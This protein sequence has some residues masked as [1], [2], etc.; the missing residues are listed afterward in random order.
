[1]A[2]AAWPSASRGCSRSDRP[3]RAAAA[4]GRRGRD[5]TCSAQGDRRRKERDGTMST[6]PTARDS[7]TSQSCSPAR[8][9]RRRPATWPAPSPPRA[10]NRRSTGG[11]WPNTGPGCAISMTTS[12]TPSP[13][14]TPSAP[15]GPGGTGR[16]RGRADPVDRPRRPA[17]ASRRRH[18]K[19][20]KTVTARVHRAL[21]LLDTHHPALAAHLRQAV[22]TGTTCRYEP[23][24]SI[25]SCDAGRPGDRQVL[26]F[27]V[28]SCRGPPERAISALPLI[29]RTWR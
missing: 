11:P 27:D 16:S 4:G 19:A 22:H 26:W 6:S 9:S 5:A 18:R 24:R 1:M 3:A 25:G 20:R 14:A 15:P 7:T 28:P 29:A 23:T 13:A 12:S 21:R 17:P 10:A 2:T 8:A